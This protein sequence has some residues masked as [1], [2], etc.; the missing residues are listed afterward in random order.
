MIPL[1]VLADAKEPVIQILRRAPREAV[2][3][4]HAWLSEHGS[5][6][7]SCALFGLCGGTCVAKAIAQ[8]GTPQA[9]DAIECALS[10][11][12]Y[13]ALLEEIASDGPQPL[14]RYFERHRFGSSC[15]LT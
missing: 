2:E 12:L 11:Y 10:K 4:R 8:S 13:P 14:I 9:V 5:S 3:L 7:Q 1:F 15:T 6:C